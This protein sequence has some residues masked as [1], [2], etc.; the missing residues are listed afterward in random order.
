MRISDWSS[1]V[2]SSDLVSVR[3][4][5]HSCDWLE[6]FAETVS[7]MPEVVEFY[8]MA[9]DVD[10]MLRVVVNDI[11]AYDRFYKKL[12]EGLNLADVTTRFAMEGIK[13]TTAVPVRGLAAPGQ[14]WSDRNVGAGKS[15]TPEARDLTLAADAP[16]F[17]GATGRS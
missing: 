7:A 9:G 1:D 3:T 4:G 12:I 16:V 5:E 2:C 15:A 11:A 8:R 17:G 10:Y 14:R 13:Y 6:R